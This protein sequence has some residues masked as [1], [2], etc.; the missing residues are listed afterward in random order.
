[1]P[2]EVGVKLPQLH[3]LRG[4]EEASLGPSSIEDGSRMALGKDEA[5]VARVLG[6]INLVPHGVEEEHTHD[7]SHGRARGWMAGAC[8]GSGLHRVDPQLGCD[9][10]QDGDL[11]FRDGRH[12]CGEG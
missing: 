8:L 3:E 6:V 7:L 11:G 9:V 1:M 12:L 10:L 4:G 5:V 2:L